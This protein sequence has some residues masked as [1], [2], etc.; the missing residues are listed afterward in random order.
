MSLLGV[1]SYPVSTEYT[2]TYIII[3]HPYLYLYL[4]MDIDIS[5]LERYIYI[6]RYI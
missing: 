4:Y 5:I 6:E 3:Y 2:H 1:H